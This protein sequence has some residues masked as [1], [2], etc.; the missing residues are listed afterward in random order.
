M[1]L[2]E[3]YE[4]YKFDDDMGGDKGGSHSYIEF[5]EQQI[6]KRVDVCLLEIGVH[7][8]HSLMMWHEFFN[9]DALVSNAFILGVDLDISKLAFP[10]NVMIGDA[11]KESTCA[12][13]QRPVFG[14]SWDY[15]IDD[16][17]HVPD[18]QI[19]T[20]RYLFPHLGMGSKYF[21]EDVNGDGGIEA[22]VTAIPGGKVFDFREKS[23]RWDDIIYMVEK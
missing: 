7:M 8:G 2:R 11:T 14:L 12:K 5:Y 23:G 16:G 1:S 9:G 21:I 22:L 13:L 18:D 10:V 6:T 20:F 19:T 4:K 15:V 17:S 3:C